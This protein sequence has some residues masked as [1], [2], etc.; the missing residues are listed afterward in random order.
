M[1]Q[2]ILILLFLMGF[3]VT[4]GQVVPEK[5]GEMQ[6][7]E[8]K[9][10]NDE[11]NKVQTI[12]QKKEDKDQPEI[13]QVPVDKQNNAELKKEQKQV[14]QA[15]KVQKIQRRAGQAILQKKQIQRRRGHK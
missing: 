3:M 10:Q 12:D 15:K 5:E 8:V 4:W 14:K 2:Y 9:K 13:K 6:K 11:K 1:K 7:T